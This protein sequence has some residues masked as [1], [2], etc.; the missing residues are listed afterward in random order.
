MKKTYLAWFLALLLSPTLNAQTC[1][2]DS[3]PATTPSS[4]YTI[5]ADGTVVDKHTGLIWKR[6]SEG[7]SGA[8]CTGGFLVKYSW[9][10]ALQR[11]HTSKFAGYPDWRLPNRQE[12]RTLVEEQC[13][14]PTI[15]AAVFP[16]TPSS[17]YWSSSPV[18]NYSGSAWIVGFGYGYGDWFYKDLGSYVRLVRGGQ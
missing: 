15:N 2:P 7:R 5:N 13:Y 12:L 8:D 3:I 16:N 1:K 11:A 10:G 4:R 6:C 18:A 14:L 9:Q 17:K